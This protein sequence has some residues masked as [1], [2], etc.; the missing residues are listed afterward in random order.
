MKITMHFLAMAA[1]FLYHEGG[2]M[3]CKACG[4]ES[5]QEAIWRIDRPAKALDAGHTLFCCAVCGH[6]YGVLEADPQGKPSRRQSERTSGFAS[7]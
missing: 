5:R 1:S 4:D 3:Q 6:I 7:V 2:I